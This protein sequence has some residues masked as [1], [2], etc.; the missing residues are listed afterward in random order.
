VA[1]KFGKKFQRRK[2]GVEDKRGWITIQ[3]IAK[4]FFSSFGLW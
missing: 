4:H 2:S 3:T 1:K